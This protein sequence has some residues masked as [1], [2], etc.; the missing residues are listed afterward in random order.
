MSCCNQ[1]CNQGRTCPKRAAR[2]E[3]GNPLGIAET[4]ALLAL[5]GAALLAFVFGLGGYIYATYGAQIAGAF[6]HLAALIS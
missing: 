5:I 3:D 2:N 6:W 1:T 4:V